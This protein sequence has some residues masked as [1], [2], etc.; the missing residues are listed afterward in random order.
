[1]HTAGRVILLVAGFLIAAG[2]LYDLLTP[3][4]PANLAAICAGSEAAQEL[5]REL[6]RALGG[7]LVA[8]GA[9]EV[10]LVIRRGPALTRFDLALILML[11]LP[12]EGV[13][14]M[15]MR[16]VRSPWHIPAAFAV[17]ALSGAIL[18]MVR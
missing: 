14:A 9:A 15:A 4:L 6:L 3:R 13:N 5:V 8:I 18:A 17:L 11:V 12:S 16:R 2:G 7:A 10:L 1:M